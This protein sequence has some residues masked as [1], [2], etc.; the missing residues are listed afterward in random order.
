MALTLTVWL[1]EDRDGS[2]ETWDAAHCACV[3]GFPAGS[4]HVETWTAIGVP[5][6]GGAGGGGVGSVHP[7]TVARTTII[8]R[9]ASPSSATAPFLQL[10]ELERNPTL[11]T[12]ILPLNLFVHVRG[13]VAGLVARVRSPRPA[14][15]IFFAAAVDGSRRARSRGPQRRNR[16]S[17]ELARNPT[18]SWSRCP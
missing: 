8:T 9:A 7:A 12:R 1:I 16:Y 17:L 10:P 11:F 6:V 13:I 4:H 3:P 2:Q 15:T 18:I 5:A 14:A